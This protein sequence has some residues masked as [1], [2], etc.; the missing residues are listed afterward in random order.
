ML[1]IQGRTKTG[2]V[3]G[4]LGLVLMGEIDKDIS[5]ELSQKVPRMK[6]EPMANLNWMEREGLSEMVSFKLRSVQQE[7]TSCM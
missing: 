4:L 1:T 5:R 7:G 2:E 3:S 6:K